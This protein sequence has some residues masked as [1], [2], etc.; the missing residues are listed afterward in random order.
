[1]GKAVDPGRGARIT[2][3]FSRS[4]TLPVLFARGIINHIRRKI[5]CNLQQRELKIAYNFPPYV[6]DYTTREQYRERERP[7]EVKS[8]S[9]TTAWVYRF[10]HISTTLLPHR[11]RSSRSR[12]WI[13]F[14]CLFFS[15]D[16]KLF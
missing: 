3:H 8:N 10:S 6:V 13:R 1:M 11:K 14:D 5:I 4:L 7:A 2:F 15:S 16:G 12:H 9:G